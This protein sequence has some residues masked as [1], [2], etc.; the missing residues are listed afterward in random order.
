MTQRMYSTYGTCI[1]VPE[2][3]VGRIPRSE[4]LRSAECCSVIIGC[5]LQ[6]RI[7][8]NLIEPSSG[9]V[10]QTAFLEP[11]RKI[12]PGRIGAAFPVGRATRHASREASGVP[13][14]VNVERRRQK[15]LTLE[16]ETLSGRSAR[17]KEGGGGGLQ[18]LRLLG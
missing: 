1:E 14:R 4:C 8:I 16:F 3:A 15:P 10:W 11:V 6:K 7:T 17:Y 2:G 5:R 12:P 13:R 18:I 9:S